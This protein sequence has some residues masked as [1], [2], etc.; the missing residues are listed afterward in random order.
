MGDV[1]IVQ[2]GA[3]FTENPSKC[4]VR[5]KNRALIPWNLSIDIFST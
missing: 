3:N 2:K 5:F 4:G 1:L